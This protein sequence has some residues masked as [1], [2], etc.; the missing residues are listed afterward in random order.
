MPLSLRQPLRSVILL[1]FPTPHLI[2]FIDTNTNIKILTPIS[3]NTALLSSSTSS[4]IPL[5]FALLLPPP[6]SFP[7]P[8]AAKIHKPQ[9]RTRDQHKRTHGGESP[10][11]S[12]TLHHRDHRRGHAGAKPASDEIVRGDGGGGGARVE[13]DEER[14]RDV[15]GDGH[16]EGG[17]E[18]DDENHRQGPGEMQRP[19]E[20][21]RERDRRVRRGD[22]DLQ[23]RFLNGKP[24]QIGLAALLDRDVQLAA[25]AGEVAVEKVA[26]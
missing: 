7:P 2:F 26:V 25:P 4:S 12:P 17:E 24:A 13:V 22:R 19:A 8:L 9:H 3:P 6:P 18:E 5:L 23:T 15:E 16:G 10:P 11:P 21:E 20:C 14:G 1:P